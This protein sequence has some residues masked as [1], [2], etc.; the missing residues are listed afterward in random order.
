MK[1]TRY[2]VACR[3][4]RY[5]GAFVQAPFMCSVTQTLNM[6]SQR[7]ISQQTPRVIS[8]ETYLLRKPICTVHMSEA[9]LS[10]DFM[11]KFR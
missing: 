6:P 4:C 3:H 1:E 8:F 7:Q 11:Q 10:C 5:N 2:I 9:G